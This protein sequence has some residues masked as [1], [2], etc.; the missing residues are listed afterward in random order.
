MSLH[1]VRESLCLEL[2][3]R[4]VSDAAYFGTKLGGLEQAILEGYHH[5]TIELQ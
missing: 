1:R 5:A 3:V 2:C 4:D